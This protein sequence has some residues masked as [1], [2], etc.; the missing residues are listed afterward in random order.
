MKN[1]VYLICLLML[2]SCAPLVRVTELD[3]PRLNKTNKLG[4][5]ND[6]VSIIYNFWAENGQLSFTFT[7]K[8]DRPVY[9]D[10]KKSVLFINNVKIPYWTGQDEVDFNTA[11]ASAALNGKISA[12][13]NGSNSKGTITH[14]E[15]ITFLA[16]HSDYSVSGISLAQFNTIPDSAKGE[17]T[18]VPETYRRQKKTQVNVR[19]FD[20]KNS[21]LQIRNY[22]TYSFK[23][24]TD[25]TMAFD[26]HIWLKQLTTMS[27]RQFNGKVLDI[28]GYTGTQVIKYSF[29]YLTP[30]GYFYHVK[31]SQ[32]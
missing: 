9:I 21:P 20:A 32:E 3:G 22:I 8:S 2:T 6:T 28:T 24:Y 25:E 26:Q 29:P 11:G 1:P 23:E 10:W 30:N 16:P 4:F 19:R 18:L 15:R 13:V 17:K 14:P 27:Q 12:G 5:E 31:P 7:N